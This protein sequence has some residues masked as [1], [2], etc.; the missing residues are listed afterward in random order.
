M[1]R[2]IETRRTDDIESDCALAR[3]GVT[4]DLG[5]SRKIVVVRVFRRS[6]IRSEAEG[7]RM[8][9]YRA[10]RTAGLADAN[11][12]HSEVMMIVEGNL[13]WPEDGSPAPEGLP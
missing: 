5:A 2:S 12:A 6:R 7:D 8:P 13:G 4:N 9:H 3:F 11:N 10:K 1:L